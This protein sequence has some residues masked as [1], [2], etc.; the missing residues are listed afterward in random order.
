MTYPLTEEDV[1]E[2]ILGYVD[3][4][5]GVSRKHADLKLLTNELNAAWEFREQMREMRITP[6]ERD[7]ARNIAKKATALRSAISE[8]FN[9]IGRDLQILL[10][11]RP[12]VHVEELD[13]V[14]STIEMVT[15]PEWRGKPSRY[16]DASET[17]KW[18]NLSPQDWFIGVE[19]RLIYQ[20]CFKKTVKISRS[21]DGLPCGE[22]IDFAIAATN[23]F[24]A[25]LTDDA[26]DGWQP[27]TADTVK[28]AVEHAK[29]SEWAGNPAA[30][31]SSEPETPE[32]KRKLEAA[33]RAAEAAVGKILA[34]IMLLEEDERNEALNRL[35]KA[36]DEA[37]RTQ[38]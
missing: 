26:L 7:W 32:R 19:L 31:E 17:P 20:R 16:F 18:R 8:E 25:P 35:N 36:F 38:K 23:A 12:V 15:S 21:K 37:F 10:G 28:K 2:E 5:A 14:I 4:L 22:F 13:Y 34:D 29:Q 30:D 1:K 33:Q 9:G 27:I 3:H 11:R 6:E 24:E